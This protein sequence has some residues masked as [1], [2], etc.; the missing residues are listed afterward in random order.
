[1]HRVLIDCKLP[2]EEVEKRFPGFWKYLQTGKARKADRGYLASRRSPWYS[3]ENRPPPPFLCTY[4][5]RTNNGRKPFRFIWNKSKATA[6]NV[7]LLLYP[8][9]FLRDALESDPTLEGRLFAALRKIDTN[10][11]MGEGRV[12]GGGLYKMEPKE[13][14]QISSDSFS[15]V[16]KRLRRTRGG[17][18][19]AVPFFSA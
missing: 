11:F 8:K 10:R 7:Y 3:Q 2:E 14:A 9:A 12:Y 18:A 5:G 16:L 4:M 1:M 6:H 15:V 13:L 19:R 17:A